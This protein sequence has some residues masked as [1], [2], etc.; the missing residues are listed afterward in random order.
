MSESKLCEWCGT[1]FKRPVNRAKKYFAKARF[2][3][4]SCKAQSQETEKRYA[5]ENIKICQC[6]NSPFERPEGLKARK[7]ELRQTCSKKCAGKLGQ[8]RATEA[9]SRKRKSK[10]EKEPFWNEF[11]S[12]IWLGRK[13]C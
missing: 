12:N 8:Q 2:C 6:C 13:L 7:W 1:E 4:L 9:G 3:S 5:R 10:P 11:L